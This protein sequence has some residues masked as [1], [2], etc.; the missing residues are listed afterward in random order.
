[1][2][3]ASERETEYRQ[4]FS[5]AYPDALRFAQRRTAP[6]RAEDAV[7]DAMLVAWRRFDQAP[8]D[9]GERRAWLFGIVRFTILNGSRSE[10][11]QSA[12]AVRIV[13]TSFADGE[14][15]SGDTALRLD[16]AR[17]WNRL[18]VAEQEVLSLAIF[19]MLTAPQAARVLRI[20]SVA[21]RARLMRARRVLQ[22]H[23]APETPPTSRLH[24]QETQS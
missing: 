21:F 17:A 10:A 2:K 22:S 9:L 12:L 15:H 18:S 1:M 13:D 23:L 5:N 19:E 16:L 24:V 4:F 11:R 7:A 14:D 20:S 8:S 6:E 3:P